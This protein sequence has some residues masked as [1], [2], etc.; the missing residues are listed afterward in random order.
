M[1]PGRPSG[2]LPAIEDPLRPRSV[3]LASLAGDVIFDE[4]DPGAHLLPRGRDSL[5]ADGAGGVGLAA[6]SRRFAGFVEYLLSRDYLLTAFELLQAREPLPPRC[7]RRG[8]SGPLDTNRGRG[9]LKRGAVE[10]SPG[11][12]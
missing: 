1:E 12:E 11:P 4:G 10:N 7:R 2:L 8:I 5:S 3:S 9:G 6:G